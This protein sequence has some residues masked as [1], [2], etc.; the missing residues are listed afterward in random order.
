[1]DDDADDG[2]VAI[3]DP[4]SGTGSLGG[5]DDAELSS[6]SEDGGGGNDSN[7][8]G[9]S[10]PGSGRTKPRR[11]AAG[12]HPPSA[13]G[14][15]R[16]HGATAAG[17]AGV[18]KRR[19]ARPAAAAAAGAS[20]ARSSAAAAEAAAAAAVALA[21]GGGG[22]AG[23][24]YSAATPCAAREQLAGRLRALRA[25]LAGLPGAAARGAY[26][27]HRLAVVDR[28]L[29][30]LRLTE[31]EGNHEA[32]GGAAERELQDLLRQLQLAA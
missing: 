12:H 4:R 11:P 8:H 2:L 26:A 25:R 1:M 5:S 3:P 28:A 17:A 24:A 32:G 29:G 31:A 21:G 6:S 20:R 23:A 22:G 15:A 19:P 30:L 14:V 18:R 10:P 9:R 13:L 27:R 16:L 7:V